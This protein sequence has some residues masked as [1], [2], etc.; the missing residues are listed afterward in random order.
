MA[1]VLVVFISLTCFFFI[2]LCMFA[3]SWFL[4]KMKKK[5]SEQDIEIIRGDEHFKAKEDIVKGP[6]GSQAVVLTIE[7]DKRFEG[8]I[9]KKEKKQ[10]T[11]DIISGGVH[12]S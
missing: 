12:H 2:G 8:E 6:S 4:I 9:M 1:V 5:K 10:R 3:F 11:L 7:D